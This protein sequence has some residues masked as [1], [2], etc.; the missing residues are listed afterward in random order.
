MQVEQAIQRLPTVQYYLCSI[1]QLL[2][3]IK[4]YAALPVFFLY[5]KKNSSI[6]YRQRSHTLRNVHHYLYSSWTVREMQSNRQAVKE[7]MTRNSQSM[8]RIFCLCNGTFVVATDNYGDSTEI[9]VILT[10]HKICPAIYL[11]F[12]QYF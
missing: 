5:C 8:R 6:Y 11:L 1:A 3:T 4:K 7:E 12:H 2:Y 9:S 10:Q